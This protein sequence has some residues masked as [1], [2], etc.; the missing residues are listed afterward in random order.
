[1]FLIILETSIG[2]IFAQNVDTTNFILKD[3]NFEMFFS[4][5]RK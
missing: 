2:D 4:N 1:M 3:K 5:N